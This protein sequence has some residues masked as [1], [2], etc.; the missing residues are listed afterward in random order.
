MPAEAGIQGR[1]GMDTGFR[2]Y[3]GS[4]IPIHLKSYL[5]LYFLRRHEGF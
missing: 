2:R 3:D 5:Y 1:K 4:L